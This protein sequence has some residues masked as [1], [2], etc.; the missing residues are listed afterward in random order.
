MSISDN[1]STI[2]CY[3]EATILAVDVALRYISVEQ[4]VGRLPGNTQTFVYNKH[5][6]LPSSSQCN[7]AS[8][9]LVVNFYCRFLNHCIC[10]RPVCFV[11]KRNTEIELTGIIQCEK[12]KH[13]QKQENI[14]NL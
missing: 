2:K 12:A 5:P 1:L 9:P 13:I 14:K 8:F 6:H 7:D 11:N 3:L 10:T 4:A